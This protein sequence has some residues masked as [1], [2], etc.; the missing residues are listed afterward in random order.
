VNNVSPPA[1]ACKICESAALDILEHTARCRRCGVLLY[2]PYPPASQPNFMTED[3]K[4]S[5]Y[6][7]SARYNHRNFTRML[8]YVTK[9]LPMAAPLLMLDFGGG[10]GQFAPICRSLFPRATVYLV[11]INDHSALDGWAPFSRRIPFADFAADN[12]KFDVIFLNDVL[13]HL[14]DPVGTLRLLSDKL[15]DAGKIFIDTPRQFWIYWLTRLLSHRLHL[16][17]LRGTVTRSHLQIWSDRAFRVAAE[18]ALLRPVKSTTWA[19]FTMP[20]EF[21]V[22]NM[23]ITNPALRFAARVV[24]GVSGLVLRNKIVCVLGK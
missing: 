10:G 4:L 8:H 12:T 14:H 13:E 9:D 17:V 23:G 15:K 21:Y 20:W 22:N 18:R 19:E 1:S 6:S 24:Y 2:Y 11:D 16:K 7:A 5:W 3:E